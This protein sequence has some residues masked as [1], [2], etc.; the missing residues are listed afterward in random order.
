LNLING[1]RGRVNQAI[2]DNKGY[3]LTLFHKLIVSDWQSTFGIEKLGIRSFE[4]YNLIKLLKPVKDDDTDLGSNRLESLFEMSSLNLNYN[5]FEN[6]YRIA[7][8][9]K[10]FDF[11]T[12]RTEMDVDYFHSLLFYCPIKQYIDMRLYGTNCGLRVHKDAKQYEAKKSSFSSTLLKEF[13]DSNKKSSSRPD[14]HVFDNYE[15]QVFAGEIKFKIGDYDIAIQELTQKNIGYSKIHYGMLP[16]TFGYAAAQSKCALLVHQ[17]LP[18]GD[19]Y[20]NKWT[21]IVEYDLTNTLDR[22]KP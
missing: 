3:S 20:T 13:A 2:V 6:F 4:Q 5:D 21:K 1:L 14:L 11:N 19:Q 22:V 8:D 9:P 10:Y 12:C 7:L 16:Y 15:R 18:L 17:R